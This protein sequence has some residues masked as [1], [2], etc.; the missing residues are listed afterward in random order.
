MSLGPLKDVN[1]I[2]DSTSSTSKPGS[3]SCCPGDHA[4]STISGSAKCSS[5]EKTLKENYNESGCCGGHDAFCSDENCTDI[6]EFSP[7]IPEPQMCGK[8]GK[9]GVRLKTCSRCKTALYCSRDCQKKDWQRHKKTCRI[10]DHDGNDLKTLLKQLTT[11]LVVE[12]RRKLTFSEAKVKAEKLFP[13]RPLFDELSKLSTHP[14]RGI[15]LGLIAEMHFYV[16]RH[17]VYV[18]DRVGRQTSLFFYLDFDNPDPY[19]TWDDLQPG[20][21]ICIK[22]PHLHIFLDGQA[23]LRID[24]ASSV[25][26]IF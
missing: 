2:N 21:Y 11:S 22:N 12:K 6:T 5:T 1:R 10:P 19:F 3:K 18:K 9:H 25:K 17:G 4:H 14:S 20:N 26:I 23:G 16:V 8:C 24:E 15:F 7:D 13:G